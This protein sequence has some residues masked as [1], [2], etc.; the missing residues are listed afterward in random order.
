M[1]RWEYTTVAVEASFTAKKKWGELLVELNRL[2]AQGW[3]VITMTAIGTGGGQ[4]LLKR[5]LEG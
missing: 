1:I 3:E 4:V 5:P 2:G